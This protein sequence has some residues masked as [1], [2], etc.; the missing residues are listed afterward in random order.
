M[1]CRTLSV[2]AL[3]RWPHKLKTRRL[4]RKLAL[5]GVGEALRVIGGTLAEQPLQPGHRYGM[6][7]LIVGQRLDI[8]VGVHKTSPG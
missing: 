6:A 7:A 5:N 4:R 2:V 8:A 1:P 3:T